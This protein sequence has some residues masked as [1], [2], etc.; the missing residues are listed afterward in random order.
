M[1]CTVNT[2]ERIYIR[3]HHVVCHTL[4]GHMVKLRTKRPPFINP[5]VSIKY[6]RYLSER[7]GAHYVLK[8]RHAQ[9]SKDC[10]IILERITMK[11]LCTTG[12]LMENLKATPYLKMRL[13]SKQSECLCTHCKNKIEGVP[14]EHRNL[15]ISTESS[16]GTYSPEDFSEIIGKIT[17]KENIFQKIKHLQSVYDKYGQETVRWLHTRFFG[18][19]RIKEKRAGIKPFVLK[20]QWTREKAQKFFY[21]YKTAQSLKNLSFFIN[22]HPE[23]TQSH[24]VHKDRKIFY[25]LKISK[26]DLQP[27]AQ[28]EKYVKRCISTA[29]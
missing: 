2:E 20:G 13:G 10:K 23:Q 12:I 4:C 27:R 22:L 18:C 9:I 26:I 21:S 29:Q 14:E 5:E 24:I 17:A 8:R 7:I 16:K 25:T 1:E 28:M 11:K 15:D 6:S 3:K 19:Y